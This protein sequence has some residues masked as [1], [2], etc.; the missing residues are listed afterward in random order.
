MIKKIFKFLVFIAFIVGAYLAFVYY[1]HFVKPAVNTNGE[2]VILYIKPGADIN[3]VAMTLDS[4]GLIGQTGNFKWLADLKNFKGRN[5]VSGKYVIR[6]GLTTN[7]LINHL[8]AGNGKQAVKITIN[9]ERDLRQISGTL[10][11]NLMIDSAA[12]NNWLTNDEHIRQLG[13]GRETIIAL[14]I[15]E[16]YYLDWD[17]SV[18]QLMT[19]MK[20]EYDKFWNEDRVSK[21]PATGLSRQEVSTLA[22]IVYWETKIPEDMRTV[23]GVYINRLEK[24]IPLQADPTLIFALGDYTIKRVLDKDKE[25]DSP[26]NTYRFTGLPPGPILIPPIACIDAVL[27][28]GR[29]E[30]Y[31]FVAHEDLSG[32][33]YFS[34]TYAEHLKYARRYQQALNKRRV[35]R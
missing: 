33:T 26:Y 30:Y 24:G 14:F 12:I 11:K 18:D 6:D 13:F 34:K 23:A 15:P 31:F 27:N 2:E 20:K 7:A 5:I 3:S 17:V 35:Y 25:L 21:L 16:T 1:Q 29:H 32:R 9:L 19:R 22:S 8:R 10:A 4:L 28:F